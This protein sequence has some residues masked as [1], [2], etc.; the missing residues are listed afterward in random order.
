[1]DSP[2]G[3]VPERAP[4]WFL[5]ATEACGGGTPDLGFFLEVSGFIGPDGGGV[6]SSGPLRGP[7]AWLV[8]P[9]GRADRACGFLGTPLRYLFLPVFLIFS[10]KNHRER[11]IPFGLRVKKG[12]KHGKNRN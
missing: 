10:I 2:F 5:V 9:G 4:D 6:A 8:R 11:I 1:M 3:R 12:Q 7:Q